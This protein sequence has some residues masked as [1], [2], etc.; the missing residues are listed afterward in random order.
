MP[1]LKG[2]SKE[3][4]KNSS[5][6]TIFNGQKNGSRTYLKNSMTN[7]INTGNFGEDG[8]DQ[9][10][11]TQ[12]TKKQ[13]WNHDQEEEMGNIDMIG[14]GLIYKENFTQKK[15]KQNQKPIMVFKNS[16]FVNYYHAE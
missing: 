5:N 13:L 2:M 10:Q 1:H 6:P 8:K 9:Y 3:L 12:E 11:H 15:I 14:R 16:D 4:M 7:L